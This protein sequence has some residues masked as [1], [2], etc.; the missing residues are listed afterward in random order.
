MASRRLPFVLAM[1]IESAGWQANS[2]VGD[3]QAD[4]RDEHCQSAVGGASD[5][6]ENSSSSASISDR[7]AWPSTW[8]KKLVL[9]DPVGVPSSCCTM[10]PARIYPW[11]KMQR[12]RAPSIAPGTFFVAQP[13]AGCITN[14]P[15]FNLRQAHDRISLRGRQAGPL[16]G[17]G[18]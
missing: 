17:N 11:R 2:C 18:G 4:P 15:G 8:L 5:P 6:W 7:R 9:P 12:S 10:G 3:T 13:W 16:A 1:E 14:M